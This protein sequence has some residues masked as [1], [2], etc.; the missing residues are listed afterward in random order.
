MTQPF[1]YRVMYYVKD[2]GVVQTD[3][4]ITGWANDD[5]W[6]ETLMGA[7]EQVEI[8]GGTPYYVFKLEP[9]EFFEDGPSR[10]EVVH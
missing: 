2:E 5:N 4:D 9:G 7:Y 1:A 6:Q 10:L 3:L 8:E